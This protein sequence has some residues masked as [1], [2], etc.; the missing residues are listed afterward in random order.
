MSRHPHLDVD[1]RDPIE[2]TA[3]DFD[4]P[5]RSELYVDEF[6]PADFD[7]I[8]LADR[9]GVTGGGFFAFETLNLDEEPF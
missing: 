5:T 1:T 4:R 3:A 9:Y 2:L 8:R 6:E 7:D